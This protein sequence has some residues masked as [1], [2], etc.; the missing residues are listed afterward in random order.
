MCR[1]TATSFQTAREIVG[2]YG[3]PKGLRIM[4]NRLPKLV[5]ISR[6]SSWPMQMT[7]RSQRSMRICGLIRAIRTAA[8]KA[9]LLPRLAL[10][11]IQGILIVFLASATGKGDLCGSLP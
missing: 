6:S 1:K 4:S 3:A 11:G 7:F 8:R 2:R 10:R 9:H 5:V